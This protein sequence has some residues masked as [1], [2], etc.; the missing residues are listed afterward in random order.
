MYLEHFGLR[1]LPF[2]TVSHAAAYI[3]LPEHSEALNTILFGLHSGEGFIKVVGEVGTGKTALCRNLLRKLDADFVTVYLPNP[4]MSANDL[5]LAVADELGVPIRPDSG[6]HDLHK[7]TREILLEIARAG[8]RVAIF[9]DEAQ[10]MPTATLE[11]L[12]LISNLESSRGKLAQVVLF[13]Q[14]ELDEKL[15]DY[16]LRQLQQR[17]AFS[18]RLTPL[19]RETCRDYV[20]RRLLHAG[21]RQHAVFTPVA[22]DRIHRGSGGIPRLINILCHKSLIAAFADREHQVGR[23]HVAR[24]LRDTEGINRWSKRPLFGT[25]VFRRSIHDRSSLNWRNLSRWSLK[26]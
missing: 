21:A 16:S 23:R 18:A 10:T 19:D 2:E 25:R 12:R 9:V 14:P 5:V 22:L 4:A 17:I 6:L 1:S 24:A 3:D 13:G 8:G 15:A 20:R 11:E 7:H 26:R